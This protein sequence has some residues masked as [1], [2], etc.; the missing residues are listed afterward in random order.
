[1]VWFIWGKYIFIEVSQMIESKIY[2]S[3]IHFISVTI[4]GV[5]EELHFV[6]DSSNQNHKFVACDTNNEVTA[7]HSVLEVADPRYQS[8]LSN[9]EFRICHIENRN[10]QTE[11]KPLSLNNQKLKGR[12][13]D[14]FVNNIMIE[15]RNNQMSKCLSTRR[16]FTEEAIFVDCYDSSLDSTMKTFYLEFN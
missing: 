14:V 4:S 5:S 9:Q 16:R 7:F 10:N 15:I 1:M 8:I 13:K 3:T 6:R 11:I 12:I 2:W